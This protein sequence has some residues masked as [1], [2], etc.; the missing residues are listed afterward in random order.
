MAHCIHLHGLSLRITKRAAEEVALLAANHVEAPPELRR[1]DLIGDVLQHA[2]DLSAFDLVEDLT[3]ELRVVALLIDRERPIT[4]DRDAP[5]R[6]RDEIVPAEVLVARQERDVWHSLKL[7][8]GPRL[9]VRA[10]VRP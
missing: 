4:D 6:R 7:H 5:I 10:A 8:R 3:A 9:R 2:D 1:A